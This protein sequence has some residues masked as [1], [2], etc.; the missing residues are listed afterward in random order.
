MDEHSTEV[1][2]LF[3]LNRKYHLFSQFAKDIHRKHRIRSHFNQRHL[4]R[5]VFSESADR[6]LGKLFLGLCLNASRLL[7]TRTKFSFRQR[8][9]EKELL[10]QKRRKKRLFRLFLTTKRCSAFN[11]KSF[12]NIILQWSDVK[13]I[14]F[15]IEVGNYSKAYL[16]KTEIDPMEK[17][18]S[19]SMH[20]LQVNTTQ[21]AH[22][23]TRLASRQQEMH[24]KSN[25]I[26]YEIEWQLRKKII[27]QCL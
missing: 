18:L 3:Q 26:F 8:R 10:Q 20:I 22:E 24:Y 13:D 4:F 5:G 19:R 14:T 15:G 7:I 12:G 6:F 1:K 9:K 17:S 27:Q 23:N 25:F 21:G 16:E 11:M 2:T